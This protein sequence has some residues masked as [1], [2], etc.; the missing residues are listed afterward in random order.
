MGAL[1]QITVGVVTDGSS[2]RMNPVIDLVNKEIQL[3]TKD[4]FNV[5]LPKNKQLEGNWRR[6][7]IESAFS[8]LYADP[9]VDIV[10]AL[11]FSSAAVAVNLT[12]H[13]KPTFALLLI[14]D[15][16]ANAP[17]K[18]DASGKHN[19][20]YISI[21]AD[22]EAELKTFRKVVEFKNV[23]LLS[24]A[25][26][27]K[28]MP[29]LRT[30]GE[31]V[32]AKLGIK[33]VPVAHRGVGDDL[34]SRLPEDVDAVLIGALPRMDEAQHSE[35]FRQLAERGLPSYSLMGSELVE[36]GVLV[37]ALP[38]QNWQHRVRRLALDI[39]A[40]LLG[41][42][43]GDMKVV[44]ESRRRLIIN[45]DTARQLNI[46]PPF[47]VLLE[48]QTI[49]AEPQGGA[50]RWTLSEVAQTAL[51]EN[52]GVRASKLGVEAGEKQVSEARSR[53]L[54]QLSINADQ[55]IR[56]GDN[57]SVNSGMFAEQQGTAS[58]R[59]SQLLYDESTWANLDIEKTLQT[60]RNAKD[61]Q[62][63]LDT[64]QEATVAFL[65][66]LK[67]QTLWDIRRETLELSR[68]NLELARDRAKVGSATNADVYRW[69][70]ELAKS[71]ADVLGAR[72][73]LRQSRES[74]NQ[75]LNR[76]LNERFSLE[77]ASL[78]DP[79]LIMNDPELVELIGNNASFQHLSNVL[80]R[81]GLDRSPEIATLMAQVAA[82]QR[83][84]TSE[85]RSYWSPTVTLTGEYSNAYQD[86][87][88]DPFSQQ[89]DDDWRLGVNLSL[90]LFE[91]G[92]RSKRIGRERLTLDQL[93]FELQ[94]TR[95]S[96]E[97]G[98][99]ARLH[100]AQASKL[101][102][103]LNRAAADAARK[104]LDLV[105]DAYSQ[106]TAGVIDLVDAQN[107]AIT[108]ELTAANAAHQFLIDLMKVQRSIG[109]FD[110]FLD[111]ARRQS[112]VQ[113]IKNEV[114]SGD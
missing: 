11:G 23:A 89:G 85:Q 68:S 8:Q 109:A 97:Q 92:A 35:L 79:T 106:G 52:L 81:L 69:E 88:E 93:R 110:F 62:K 31:K 39:Q 56:N 103:N 1:R 104:N 86:S 100:T 83:T 48:A 112:I 102:I 5:R 27:T 63:E 58:L 34:M 42:D 57:P 111:D 54:P 76:S 37:T 24:D 38:A 72:A 17:R 18:G 16:L 51:A 95:R 25:L 67:S 78:E 65:N 73:S 33:L 66:V 2:A 94:D 75:L 32:A 60:A 108:A 41:D 28:V 84:V 26:M 4:E 91:G 98:I 40:A 80:I 107:A 99:R 77:P 20:T 82:Q 59:L 30:E 19:L 12:K 45:M 47:E 22:L 53:L 64:V 14:D 21:Q 90:P 61:K 10:I 87:R 101:S 50:M 36:R 6:N 105:S 113:S 43:P 55:Q 74:L 46:S 96:I 3:L 29:S 44:I 13:P 15:R 71:K 9:E 7:G 114:A 49:N 70:S